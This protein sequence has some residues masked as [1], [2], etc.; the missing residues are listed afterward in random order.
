MLGD[1]LTARQ[2]DFS[3]LDFFLWT[4]VTSDNFK[5]DRKLQEMTDSL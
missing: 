3:S 4:A 1:K 5:I 2:L